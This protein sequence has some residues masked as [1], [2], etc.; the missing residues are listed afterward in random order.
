MK[1]SQTEK[2]V[3]KVE[4]AIV[5]VKQEPILSSLD[6]LCDKVELALDK[7][8]L[9]EKNDY[10]EGRVEYDALEPSASYSRRHDNFVSKEI[11][12]RD[13]FI[14]LDELHRQG[15]FEEHKPSSSGDDWYTIDYCIRLRFTNKLNVRIRVLRPRDIVRKQILLYLGSALDLIT[16]T[17]EGT[18]IFGIANMQQK[19]VALKIDQ[20]QQYLIGLDNLNEDK[21]VDVPF[22]ERNRLYVDKEISVQLKPMKSGLY[23]HITDLTE[24]DDDEEFDDD[25]DEPRGSRRSSTSN[26]IFEGEDDDDDKPA[27]SRCSR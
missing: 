17:D 24:D 6:K 22:S 21:E 13:A 27:R 12:Y 4:K 16:K 26:E 3:P 14:A 25:D 23:L 18:E 9:Y 20:V 5:E 8:F 19:D 7:Y 2:Q 1:K 15:V 11:K 10:G